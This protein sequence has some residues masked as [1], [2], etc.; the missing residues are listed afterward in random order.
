M[1]Q[2]YWKCKYSSGIQH[3]YHHHWCACLAIS[4]NAH[5]VSH[6]T[7]TDRNEEM[8]NYE[9]ISDIKQINSTEKVNRNILSNT[10]RDVRRSN[11]AFPQIL[12][13]HADGFSQSQA[14]S[15]VLH[16]VNVMAMRLFEE[17][18]LTKKGNSVHFL[19][20]HGQTVSA[21]LLMI[22]INLSRGAKYLNQCQIC[23]GG[24]SFFSTPQTACH[25]LRV[26]L[27]IKAL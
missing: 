20:G 23:R 12:M 27:D 9:V 14:Q 7:R 10:Q 26:K 2:F 3:W 25:R 15:R 22:L 19:L 13:S 4:Q 6:S 11:I 1:V 21:W 16:I 5:S 8:T 17:R 24:E 18:V